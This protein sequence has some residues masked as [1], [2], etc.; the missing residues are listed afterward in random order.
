M[1]N[2][3]NLI[4]PKLRNNSVSI[5]PGKKEEC[6]QTSIAVSDNDSNEQKENGI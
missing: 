6:S 3:Q 5:K 2:L 4:P 1:M